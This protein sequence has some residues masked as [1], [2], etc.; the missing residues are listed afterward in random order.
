MK[1]FLLNTTYFLLFFIIFLIFLFRMINDSFEINLDQ[2][3]D[4]DEYVFNE[5]IKNLSNFI[6]ENSSINLILGSSMMED[7]MIPDAMDEKWFSFSVARQNI[8]E[9]YKLLSHINKKIKIDTIIIAIEPFDFPETYI[10]NR[11]ESFP[12]VSG[13]FHIY[14]KDTITTIKSKSNIKGNL[15]IIKDLYWK[16][17]NKKYVQKEPRYVS[18][19]GF[20]GRI[21]NAGINL[22]S[23]FRIDSI[24]KRRET[25]YFINVTN[26]ANFYYF[27]LF[28]SLAKSLKIKVLYLILPKSKYYNNNIKENGNGIIWNNILD[29]LNAKHIEIWNYQTINTDFFNFNFFWDETHLSYKGAKVFT[30]M[31]KEKIIINR[32]NEKNK[33]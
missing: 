16:L 30:N 2:F 5:K 17:N 33:L 21:N 32:T 24:Q 26:P 15:Q 4:F 7:A 25:L 27:N 19:Q 28:D 14:E 3:H 13:K 10:K 6:S 23:L 31:I 29:S 18:S 8:Y 11:I 1:K 12:L 9:S 20:S 22:D